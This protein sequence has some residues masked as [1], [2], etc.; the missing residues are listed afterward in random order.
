[1]GHNCHRELSPTWNNVTGWTQRYVE[2]SCWVER[3]QTDN[4][5]RT[6]GPNGDF[7]EPK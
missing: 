4:Y 6:C 2:T 5:R 1:M 3:N 7:F